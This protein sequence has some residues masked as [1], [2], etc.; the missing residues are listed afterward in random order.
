VAGVPPDYF[1]A[2]GQLWGNSIYRWDK[3]RETGYQWW[4]D[5]FRAVLTQ[6]DIVRLDHFRGFQAYWEVPAGEKTA[7]KGRWIEGPGAELFQVVEAKLGKLPIIAEN[8]GVIT[9]EVEAIRKRF[10][11]PGMS[12]LQFAF[13][14]D[15]QAPTFRPHNYPRE[16]VA[17]TGTHDNDTTVGWWHSRAGTGST[18]TAEEIEEEHEYTKRYLRTD[19]REINWVF[20]Q[21][22]LSSVA[23]TVLAPMQVWSPHRAT[24]KTHII[25]HQGNERRQPARYYLPG[26]HQKNIPR[27]DCRTEALPASQETSSL[28]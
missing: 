24:E 25:N 12:I 21:T 17:Y 16:L 18:R 6:V 27:T 26:R 8:L 2:T 1:S 7:I 14:N 20:I 5:R 15:P 28:S 3:L 19:G 22:I 11:Y 10:G 23:D 13:G 9:P 4:I